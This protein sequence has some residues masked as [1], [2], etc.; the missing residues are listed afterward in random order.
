MDRDREHLRLLSIF[1]WIAAGLTVL[2][3][4]FSL[5][6]IALGAAVLSGA[7]DGGPDGPPPEFLGVFFLGLGV[8]MFLFG[9]AMAACL[10]CSARFLADRKHRTFCLVVA[11][12]ACAS[13]PIGTLLGVFTILVLARPS[14]RE[15]FERASTP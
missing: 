7:L 3:S 14:V 13:F 9:L 6:Y 10:A 8:L 11:G 4:L 1:H 12:V 5:I 2:L 15:L